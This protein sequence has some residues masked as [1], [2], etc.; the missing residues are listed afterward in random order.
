MGVARA[1]VAVSTAVPISSGRW[2]RTRA[3]ASTSSQARIDPAR[4][5]NCKWPYLRNAAAFGVTGV[6]RELPQALLSPSAS[7]FLIGELTVTVTGAGMPRPILPMFWRVYEI[8]ALSI[9]N[10]GV[11]IVHHFSVRTRNFR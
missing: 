10:R 8:S 11:E 9:A 2:A 5:E 1:Y 7:I 4:A 3:L 6:H